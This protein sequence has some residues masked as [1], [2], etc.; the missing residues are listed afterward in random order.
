MTFE[1]YATPKVL[2]KG[3]EEH[4]ISLVM[5]LMNFFRQ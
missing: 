4:N 1:I 2:R 3:N 5:D